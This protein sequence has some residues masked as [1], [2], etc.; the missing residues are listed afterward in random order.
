MVRPLRR[1]LPLSTQLIGV[2]GGANAVEAH[3]IEVVDSAHRLCLR[4]GVRSSRR[5]YARVPGFEPPAARGIT[6]ERGLGPITAAEREQGWACVDATVACIVQVVREREAKN[7]L[8]GIST[9]GVKSDD[10][11][12]IE[13]AYQGPRIPDFVTRLGRFLASEQVELCLPL[14]PLLSDG[15]CAGLGEEHSEDGAFHGVENACYVASDVTV[16]ESLKLGHHLVETD[17]FEHRFPRCWELR[18]A[19]GNPYEQL[20]SVAAHGGGYA[21]R[22]RHAAEVS[23]VPLPESREALGLLARNVAQLL[24]IR[25]RT[26]AQREF[27]ST[28]LGS[29]PIALDR[30]VLGKSL[31][32]LYRDPRLKPCFR[33]PLHAELDRCIDEDGEL[34]KLYRHAVGR[35]PSTQITSSTLEAAPAIGAAAIALIAWETGSA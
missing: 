31:T 21:T 4:A 2:E 11:L 18:D 12:G 8:I 5:E 1:A 9:H 29:G 6:E 15:L 16:T 26:L 22:S 7:V 27:A 35:R 30:I 13:F 10:G 25:M 23:E 24:A 28:L 17:T 19:H 34:T 3:E 33:E 32:T 20:V 14:L